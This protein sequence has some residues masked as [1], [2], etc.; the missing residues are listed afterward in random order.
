MI[1]V[2][3]I[4]SLGYIYFSSNAF[5]YQKAKWYE[6]QGNYN[7]AKYIF[8]QLE[9]YKDANERKNRCIIRK[10]QKKMDGSMTNFVSI[11]NN[12]VQLLRDR[13]ND[14]TTS[15]HLSEV[16]AVSSEGSYIA[17]LMLDGQVKI[18]ESKKE[19]AKTANLKNVEKWSNIIA[20][21]TEFNGIAGVDAEG[22]V[23]Y[24]GEMEDMFHETISSW[25]DIVSISLS[26]NILMGLKKDGSVVSAGE[27]EDK[28][29][30]ADVTQWKDIIDIKA[31]SNYMLGLKKDGTVVAN[32]FIYDVW[33]LSEWKNIISISGHEYYCCG[34]KSD[35]TV[36]FAGNADNG[37]DL[38]DDWDDLIEIQCTYLD[39]IGIKRDGSYLS[40]MEIWDQMQQ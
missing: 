18:F 2:I 28:R 23:Y 5:T 9:N 31:S 13:Y 32:Q 25:E 40:T 36:V 10:N 37:E 29:K 39:T 11:E 12:T 8:A 34:L 20:I 21:D 33:N 4:F 24:H 15:N 3:I 22:H 6:T 1:S 7:K 30:N 35:G 26:S 16:L 17:Y 38:V 19:W 14:Y 27:A